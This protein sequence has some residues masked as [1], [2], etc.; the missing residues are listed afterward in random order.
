MNDRGNRV[1][2]GSELRLAREHRREHVRHLV[3]R[4]R[5][6]TRQHLEEDN[7]EGPNVGALVDG[8]PLR[9]LG[10]HV[11][12]G[13]KDEAH[14]GHRRRGDRRRERE[15]AAT[16]HSRR[17]VDRL[18]QSEV[19]HLH[20]PARRQLDVGGFQVA[21]DD[22]CAVRGLERIAD[23]FGGMKRLV[24]R[25][26]PLRD[27]IRQRGALDE[28][29]HQRLR[30]GGIFQTVDPADVGMVERGQHLRFAAEPRQP[31]GI[32]REGFGKDLQ[33]DIPTE[34]RIP[35][36]IHFAHAALANQGSDLI[37]AKARTGS[38]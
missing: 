25:Q 35:G 7:P 38:Q 9:L 26:W 18:G 10:A 30:I 21:V 4:K 1:W 32:V 33:R 28:L 5:A 34:L 17:G 13:A 24:D 6:M 16:A 12:G 2:K 3:A 29:E 19:E 37:R 11:R 23:L 22:P 20:R 27:P 15:A 14:L 31:V 36:S 8:F